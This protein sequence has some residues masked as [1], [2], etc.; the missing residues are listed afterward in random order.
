MILLEVLMPTGRKKGWIKIPIKREILFIK[1]VIRKEESI[2]PKANLSAWYID[3]NL[4]P[5]GA[6][7]TCGAWL[8]NRA[9]ITIIIAAVT[10]STIV[11]AEA[12]I[13]VDSVVG[14]PTVVFIRW[15]DSQEASCRR[16]FFGRLI[17]FL[18]FR[19]GVMPFPGHIV[20]V[21]FIFQFTVKEELEVL[22]V[23]QGLVILWPDP[24]VTLLC[25]PVQRSA[26]LVGSLGSNSGDISRLATNSMDRLEESEDEEAIAGEGW[27]GWCS[28]Y[29]LEEGDEC[30]VYRCEIK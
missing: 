14:V 29:Q 1:E 9:D 7:E 20:I 4:P 10:S 13:A 28:C 18:L 23:G 3:T 27:A 19:G 5:V 6:W 15:P 2:A 24:E 25:V 30:T 26:G 22:A 8:G 12:I 16:V 11:T 21:I 17:I